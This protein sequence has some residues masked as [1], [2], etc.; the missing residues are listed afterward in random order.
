MIL[1]ENDV[2]F[3]ISISIFYVIVTIKVIYFTI[4]N[5]KQYNRLN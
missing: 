1:S 5:H 3:N 4:I 2:S